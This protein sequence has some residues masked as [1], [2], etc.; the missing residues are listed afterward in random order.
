MAWHEEHW[1]LVKIGLPSGA[2]S[3]TAAAGDAASPTATIAAPSVHPSFFMIYSF[4]DVFLEQLVSAR[5]ER[6]K[7]ERVARDVE[8]DLETVLELQLEEEM[9]DVLLHG[10]LG[11]RERGRD[12]F[13]GAPRGDQLGHLELPLRNLRVPGGS[14]RERMAHDGGRRA[15]L[16]PGRSRG[17][18]SHGAE[19][20][21]RSCTSA[22]R[23]GGALG[24]GE[25]ETVGAAR[26]GPRRARVTATR[27]GR[28]EDETLA[29]AAL[30]HRENRHIRTARPKGADGALAS[31]GIE[32]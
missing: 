16:V 11:D 27:P 6:S 19:Q 4:A 23:S 9:A 3:G 29:L 17:D 2:L 22:D 13:V 20:L 18:E 15:R 7:E 8:T 12:L 31:T 1:N 25:L 30:G 5:S 14:V 24:D 10:R 21:F 26:A 32:P 28:I